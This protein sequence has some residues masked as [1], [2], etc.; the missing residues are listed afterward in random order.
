MPPK[1]KNPGY[2][3][4]A[5]GRNLVNQ[6]AKVGVTGAINPAGNM[7][8]NITCYVCKKSKPL[9]QYAKRQAQRFQDT[10]HNPYAP[11]GRSKKDPKV[12]CRDCTPQQTTELKCCICE[13]VKGLN[14]FANNQ[15]RNRTEARCIACL[16]SVLEVEPDDPDF[17]DGVH[18]GNDYED[19]SDDDDE[20][21]D[22]DEGDFDVA[23]SDEDEKPKPIRNSVPGYVRPGARNQAAVKTDSWGRPRKENHSVSRQETFDSFDDEEDLTTTPT[24]TESAWEEVSAAGRGRGRGRGAPPPGQSVPP[25]SYA[26]VANSRVLNNSMYG[27]N[28]STPLASSSATPTPTTTIPTITNTGRGSGKKRWA[29]PAKATSA[30]YSSTEIRE[31]DPWDAYARGFTNQRDAGKQT[32]AMPKKK[33]KAT[34]IFDDDDEDWD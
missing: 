7:P 34:Q 20:S 23:T 17:I 15:R 16:S 5:I 32:T 13:K 9:D 27:G 8:S 6:R 29:K 22:S 30:K 1:S 11:G 2:Y 21:D 10:I 3:G 24:A 19:H 28:S 14:F 25:I 4:A 18:T 26:N 31:S 33:K 12:T